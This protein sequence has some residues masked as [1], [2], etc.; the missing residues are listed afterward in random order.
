MRIYIAAPYTKGDQSLNVRRAIIVA[1]RIIAAGH[2][3][4]VPLLYHLWRLMSPHEY[5]YWMTLDLSWIEACD[6]LVWLDGESSGRDEEV[7][8]AEELGKAVYTEV[9]LFTFLDSKSLDK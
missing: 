3:P 9:E 8:V 5:G 7:A 1:E 6:A 4:F 2:I